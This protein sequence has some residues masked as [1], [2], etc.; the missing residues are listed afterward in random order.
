MVCFRIY[1]PF[2]QLL[3]N[4]TFIGGTAY[5]G[6]IITPHYDSLLVKVT[7][8]GSTY[9]EARLKSLRAITEFRIKGVKTN[10]PF[11]KN[12]LKSAVFEKGDCWTT[13]IDDEKERGI[14]E[15][16]E[17][18]FVFEREKDMAGR[19]LSYLAGVIVNGSKV[20]GIFVLIKFPSYFL[21]QI[22]LPGIRESDPLLPSPSTFPSYIPASALTTPLQATSTSGFR[23]IFL[24]SGAEAFAKAIRKHD[25]PLIMDTTWRDAHQSL[26]A[27][28]LRTIDLKRIGSLTS[29]L[30]KDCFA[31]ECWG[32]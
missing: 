5:Q 26:L 10:I 27:T 19:L 30:F 20:Q 15:N 4:I 9:E 16:G 3:L 23:H 1:H 17:G 8:S 14:D 28:R 21:G 31:L 12:L 11:L 13:F 2:K 25:K 24:S 32:V 18:L 29:H 6:A 7:C 22:G